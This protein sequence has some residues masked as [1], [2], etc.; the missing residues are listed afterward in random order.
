MGM[1]S[2]LH[3]RLWHAFQRWQ[4]LRAT[5]VTKRE[6]KLRGLRERNDVN[7]YIRPLIFAR[8]TATGYETVLRGLLEIARQNGIERL[9]DI[10]KREWRAFMDRAFEERLAARTLARYASAVAK[11][12]CL[13]G[14]SASGIAF[15]AKCQRTIRELVSQGKIASPARATPSTEVVGRAIEILREWDVRHFER[16]DEPRAY[17]LVARLQVETSCRS[18]SA[19]ARVTAESLRSDNRIALSAKGGRIAEHVLSPELHR[20]LS[21]YLGTFGGRLADQNGYRAAWKRAIEAAG[22]HVTGTHGLRRLSVQDFYRHQYHAAMADGVSPRE[23][24]D[25]A[26]GDAIEKLG[27]SRDRSDHRRIYLGR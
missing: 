23:A 11:L 1:Q 13:T 21:I 7:Q 19:T 18:I 4:E 8:A 2:E 20:L 24:A 22:G 6:L 16:T 14:R 17:H 3:D 12:A 25:R 26:A 9:D 10:G 15:S 27:H 5:G